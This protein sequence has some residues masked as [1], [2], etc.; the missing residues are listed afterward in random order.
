MRWLDGI[1]DSIQLG[2]LKGPTIIEELGNELACAAACVGVG[3][4]NN[5]GDGSHRD[6]LQHWV[7]PQLGGLAP[8]A[9]GDVAADEEGPPQAPED[10]KQDEGEELSHV[11]GRVIL[12]V[13]EDEAAVP[14]WIDGSQRE[15]CHQ[16]R[17]KGPPQGL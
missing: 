13:E 14:E 10:P 11:P 12:H 16:G 3:V 4:G 7:L 17:K 5:G 1:T 15:G 6:D 9:P 2:G 8:P